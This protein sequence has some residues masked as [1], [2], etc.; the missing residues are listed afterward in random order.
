MLALAIWLLATVLYF[1]FSRTKNI[2]FIPI[3]LSLIVL[4][5]AFGPVNMF[6]I[7]EWSQVSRLRNLL[8]EQGI[9]QQGKITAASSPVSKEAEAEISSIVNYLSEHHGFARMQ[10]WFETDLAAAIDSAT[11]DTEAKWVRRSATREEVLGLMGLE[12]T[13]MNKV[14][15]ERYFSFTLGGYPYEA[16]SEVYNMAGYD[17]IVELSLRPDTKRHE[18]KLDKYPL[19]V[20]MAGNRVSFQ[21]EGE[22]LRLDLLPILKKLN[23]RSDDVPAKSDLTH[24]IAGKQAQLQIVIKE[25]SGSQK[26]KEFDTTNADIL[27]FVKLR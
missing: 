22:T 26:G 17:Y 6:V 12:Y 11:A 7:S 8:Q 19:I 10:D 2:K 13:T 27:L 25:L 15:N 20:A 24:R 21:L 18:L 3:T 5:V 1:L 14:S 4:L 9:M 16:K 23:K